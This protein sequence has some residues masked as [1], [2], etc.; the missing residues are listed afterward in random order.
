MIR[1]YLL[2]LI[3]FLLSS[4]ATLINQKTVNLNVHSDTDSVKI[5]VNND[6]TRWYVTPTRINVERSPNDLLILAKKIVSK[7]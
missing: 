4:C 6:T 2:L 1:Y 5:C 3:G 7:K